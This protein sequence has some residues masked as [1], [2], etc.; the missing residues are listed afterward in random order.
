MAL[1]RQLS[2]GLAACLIVVSGFYERTE[3]KKLFYFYLRSGRPFGLAGIYEPAITPNG[4]Q[5]SFVIVTTTPNKLIAP[6]HDRMPAIIP[7]NQQSLWLDCT[8]Y[9]RKNLKSL[10]VPYPAAEMEM[11]EAKFTASRIS[12]PFLS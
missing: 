5:S 11:R 8:H 4:P 6:L 7:H 1:R 12:L 10:L 2:A 3:G 9:D